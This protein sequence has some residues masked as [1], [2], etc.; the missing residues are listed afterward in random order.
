MLNSV[1]TP[2]T[3]YAMCTLKLPA[4]VI[5]NIDRSRKQCLWRGNSQNNRGG[6]LAAWDMVQKP[7]A[8]GGAGVLNLRLQNDALLIKQL[9]KFY[10]KSD[11]PW[12]KLIWN[13]Y[14]QNKVPH[15][16]REVGSF[17]WK[18]VLRLNTLY[19]GIA[20]CSI[21]DG[22]TVPFWPDLWSDG[23]LSSIFPRLFSY[24][25]N[26]NVSVK[27]ILE[28]EDLES[29]FSLPLSAQAF[30]EYLLIQDYLSIY[31][32]DLQGTDQWSFIWGSQQ[33]LSHLVLRTKP[34]A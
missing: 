12:V 3:T 4:G 23:V 19:R 16:S 17:W 5:E 6:N 18:D 26:P 10:G 28:A 1:I 24:A 8:K 11:T 22:S 29:V 32:Y 21:G 2:I 33:Y 7:K 34:N 9:H 15:A 27:Q 20:K 30:D 14:Y 13:K 25:S 31:N